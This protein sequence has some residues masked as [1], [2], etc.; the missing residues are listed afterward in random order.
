MESAV[1]I[2]ISSFND[3]IWKQAATQTEEK[4][5]L[6]NTRKAESTIRQQ[7]K[8]AANYVSPDLKNTFPKYNKANYSLHGSHNDNM[9]Q[10]EEFFS[11]RVV[12]ALNDF[13]VTFRRLLHDSPN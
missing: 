11:T 8:L 4:S 5:P 6:T 13:K 10:H 1:T 3:K 7:K 12:S 9:E 2:Y